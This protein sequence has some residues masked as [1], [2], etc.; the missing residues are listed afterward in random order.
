MALDINEMDEKQ[1]AFFERARKGV[2][3]YLNDKGGKLNMSELHEHSL[4][5]Y[6]IQHQGFSQMMETF[7]NEGLVEFDQAT[8]DVSVTELGKEFIIK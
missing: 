5:K 4:N 7:V 6:L 3:K 8:Y 1:R 2:L